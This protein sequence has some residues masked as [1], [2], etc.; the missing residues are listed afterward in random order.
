MRGVLQQFAHQALNRGLDLLDARDVGRTDNDGKIGQA[1]AQDFASV[2]AEERDSQEISKREGR[3][4][5]IDFGFLGD[6]VD[7][8]SRRLAQEAVDDAEVEKLFP[9]AN[10]CTAENNLGYVLGAD[11]VGDG[12][13][14]AASFEADDERAKIFREAQIGLENLWILLASGDYTKNMD[15]VELGIE[16]PGHACG[17]R[18]EVLTGRTAGNADGDAFAHAPVFADLLRVHVRFK[19]AIHLFGD[20]AQGEFA[21]GDEIAAAKEI[22]EG[23]LDFLL[24]VN[25]TAAH[26]IDKRFGSEVHHHGLGSAERNPIGDGFAD[27]DARDGADRGSDT[28]NVL[29]VERGNDVDLRGEKFL[30]VFIA[31]AVAAAGNVGVGEFVDEDDAGAAG[32]DGVNIHLFERSAFVIDFPAGDGFEL[33]GEFLDTLAAVSFDDADDDVFA[34]AFAAEGFAQHAVGFADTGSVT[35][36]EFENPPCAGRGRGEFQPLFGL[37]G[38]VALFSSRRNRPGLQ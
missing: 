3:G 31:F 32:E 36:E 12:V 22:L 33:G 34:T 19:A 35:E 18:D 9:I 25:V 38:Q 21:E 37:L 15:D 5:S 11:E 23:L 14:D 13:G 17:A 8:D 1:A 10:Q 6:D 2:V 26:A 29:D 4:M 20:L 27:S 7:V 30:N 28:F 24:A 16:A